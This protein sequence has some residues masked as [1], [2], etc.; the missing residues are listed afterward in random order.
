MLLIL[1]EYWSTKKKLEKKSCR[2]VA[3]NLEYC[4][5]NY[6]PVSE[7]DSLFMQIDFLFRGP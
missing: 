3:G 7:H 1:S 2:E 6:S 5:P 4:S